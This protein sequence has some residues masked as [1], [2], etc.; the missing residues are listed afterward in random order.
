[1][2]SYALMCER[3]KAITNRKRPNNFDITKMVGVSKRPKKWGF[4][5]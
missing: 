4:Y 3:R 5:N 2:A 1:M